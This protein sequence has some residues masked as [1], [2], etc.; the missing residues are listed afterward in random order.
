MPSSS[1]SV[2]K[3]PKASSHFNASTPALEEEDIN[4][5]EDEFK[6]QLIAVTPGSAEAECLMET[7]EKTARKISHPMKKTT[8][9]LLGIFAKALWKDRQGMS[10]GVFYHPV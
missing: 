10:Q 8:A 4:L 9:S 5:E 7:L 3:I 2:F 6:Q 1:S